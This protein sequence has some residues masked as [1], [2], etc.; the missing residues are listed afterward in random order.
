MQEVIAKLKVSKVI[1]PEI[2]TLDSAPSTPK[3]STTPSETTPGTS[4]VVRRFLPANVYRS[5]D[6]KHFV[7]VS[8]KT[9]K[10][11]GRRSENLQKFL[12]GKSVQELVDAGS[13]VCAIK[14]LGWSQSHSKISN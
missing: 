10:I 6:G 1:K 4:E 7:N 2:I 14:Y 5:A 13:L 8:Q 3:P 9:M 12:D 11:L